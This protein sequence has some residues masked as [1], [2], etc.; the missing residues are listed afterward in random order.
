MNLR[1]WE[2]WEERKWEREGG[3]KEVQYYMKFSKEF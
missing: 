2:I 1:S 3:I